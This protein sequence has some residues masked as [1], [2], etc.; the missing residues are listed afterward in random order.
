[1]RSIVIIRAGGWMIHSTIIIYNNG[2]SIHPFII[3][4]LHCSFGRFKEFEFHCINIV[5][6]HVTYGWQVSASQRFLVNMRI[7]DAQN[8]H[9]IANRIGGRYA[10][11]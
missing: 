4:I 1:M 7:P 11:M 3:I 8:V 5:L 10:V 9:Q 6:N 2:A